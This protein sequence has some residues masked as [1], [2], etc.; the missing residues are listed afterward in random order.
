MRRRLASEDIDDGAEA[1]AE[2]AQVVSAFGHSD[3]APRALLFR[4]LSQRSRH[5]GERRSRDAHAAKRIPLVCVEACRHDHDVR[6]ELAQHGQHHGVEHGRFTVRPAPP[7]Y[8][9]S[10]AAPVPG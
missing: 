5:G 8:P 10:S 1:L 7:P 2:G 9:I 4:H 3:Q 6:P